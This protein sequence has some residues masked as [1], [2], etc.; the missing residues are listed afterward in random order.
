MKDSIRKQVIYSQ[1]ISQLLQQIY[2]EVISL[3]Y[4]KKNCWAKLI[5]NVID[6]SIYSSVQ[7]GIFKTIQLVVIS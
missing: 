4:K 7:L 3:I 5:F 6:L 2:K 1:I